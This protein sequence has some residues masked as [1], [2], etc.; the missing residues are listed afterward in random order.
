M[1]ILQ[2]LTI[3]IIT[4]KRPRALQQC[5]NSIKA[6]KYQ[7]KKI[8][9]I[10]SLKQHTFVPE[11]RNLALKQCRTK[12]FAFV[13]D[14]CVLDQNWTISAYKFISSRPELAFVVGKTL[15]LNQNQYLA[16]ISFRHYSDWFNLNH[17][18]DTKNVIFN[19]QKIRKLK[20]DPQFKMFEDVDFN[21]QLIHSGL[22][23]DYNPK[24]IVHHP[25]ISNLFKLI[26]KN[27]YRGQYKAKITRKWGNID[28]FCPSI[29]SFEH[30]LSFILKIAFNLGYLKNPPRPI[31]IV[32][33]QDLGANGER[34]Q[35]FYNFLRHR[36]YFVQTLNSQFEFEKVTASKKYLIIYGYPLLKYKILKFFHDR[37]KLDQSSKIILQALRLRGNIIHRLLTKN[38]SSLAILQYPED[39]LTVLKKRNYQTLY[40]SPTIYFR[41]LELSQLYSQT[42]ISVIRNLETQVYKNSD[43]VSFHWYSFFELAKKYHL[44]INHPLVLNW[45]CSSPP[46]MSK[47][48]KL[49]PQKIIH[50]GKLNS[51]W[52]NPK[53]LQHLSQTAN[54]DIYSYENPDPQMYPNLKNFQGYLSSLQ[55]LYQYQFGLIT[56]SQDDLRSHGFSAKYPLYLSFGLPVFCPE[57]RQDNFFKEATIYYNEKNFEKQLKKYSLKENWLKK[58]HAALKISQYLNWDTTLIPLLDIIKTLSK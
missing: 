17:P 38:K 1:P 2:D 8:I 32:N 48:H 55:Q 13:D 25:E 43:F 12:Y 28:D 18:L 34:L 50:L 47:N 11:S 27:Y 37:L 20:F 23:G 46:Q 58:H 24:M 36:H 44:K 45:G 16:K 29:P 42:T 7:P 31:T 39:M 30:P 15:L 5:L 35:A 57:W 6:Q 10:D 19:F 9:V 52:V 21:Q 26:K 22:I 33:H 3:A 53:L 40:D 4:Y 51:Y 14:D 54:V 56:L 49:S 41:E